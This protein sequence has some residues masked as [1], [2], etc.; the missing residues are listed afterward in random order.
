MSTRI[1][2]E[3]GRVVHYYPDDKQEELRGDT[4][5]PCAA[6]ICYVHSETCVNLSVT[7]HDGRQK[8]REHVPLLMDTDRPVEEGGYARWM[9]YQIGQAAK[10][11]EFQSQLDRKSP[12]EDSG[13]AVPQGSHGDRQPLGPGETHEQ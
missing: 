4:S 7:T 6:Q 5:Q 13:P 8:A 9:P 12:A 3:V 10:T 2:P 11:E 1:K